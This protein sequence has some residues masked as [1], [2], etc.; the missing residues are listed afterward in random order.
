MSRVIHCTCTLVYPNRKKS[1]LVI[2]VGI[3][4]GL[5]GIRLIVTSIFKYTVVRNKSYQNDFP[6]LAKS[7]VHQM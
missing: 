7:L 5:C 4:T 2:Y 3:L 1:S 6:I